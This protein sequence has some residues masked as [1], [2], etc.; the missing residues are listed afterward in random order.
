MGFVLC[1]SVVWMGEEKR[2]FGWLAK[3][4]TV[5]WDQLM[6]ACMPLMM[7]WQHKSLLKPGRIRMVRRRRVV[8]VYTRTCSILVTT[9]ILVGGWGVGIHRGRESWKATHSPQPTAHSGF[10]RTLI[11][12]TQR[13]HISILCPKPIPLVDLFMFFTFI[14][15]SLNN[16]ITH[17]HAQ[18]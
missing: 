4:A 6:R 18:V 2:V 11:L 12:P 16:T 3:E 15:L 13:T 8:D 5:R 7:Q 17:T 14:T 1:V 10:S 9:R